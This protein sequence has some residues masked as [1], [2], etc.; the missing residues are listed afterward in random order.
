M[1]QNRSVLLD[2]KNLRKYFPITEGFMKRVVGQVK[3]V[4]GVSFA[5]K[6][7]ETLGLI[8]ESGCGKTTV[9]RSILRA[10]EPTAGE[11]LFEDGGTMV[12]VC[13]LSRRELRTFR[14]HM[15]MVFQDPYS[16]LNPRMTVFDIVA[17][18][19]V[20]NR[21][22]RGAELEDRVAELLRVVG[23]DPQFMRRY[24][25]AF[26]GGQRQRIGVARALALN[27]RLII[28]DEPVSALDVS[29]QAQVLNLLQELQER[30]G[31]TY[32][33]IS[34]DLAVVEH[35][36][37]RIAIMYVG[38][39]VE[40]ADEETLFA[41]PKHPYTEALLAAVPKP[42]PAYRKR[43]IPLQGEVADPAN[44]P[45]GCY[46]HPR[47]PYAED[48]CR[49]DLPELVNVAPADSDPHYVRCHFSDTLSLI[50]IEV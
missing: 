3:A 38:Q 12:D 45:S 9:G 19:L 25:H 42:N 50:G 14:K 36:S 10:I 41:T 20:V 16:S 34:H 29:V 23:L 33:F 49:E 43:K 27:P 15:Q 5:V 7:Q 28:G 1:G 32:L 22:T 40:L 13:R 35:I 21:I 37:D 4:D 11:V 39:I 17:E 2:V 26:S 8:G 6:K 48:V 46:F 18:P 47:C 24:P 44:P 31:L 30:M